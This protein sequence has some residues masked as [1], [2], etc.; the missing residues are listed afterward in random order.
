MYSMR[1]NKRVVCADGFN[2]SVQA[3]QGAYC[4]PRKDDAPCYSLVEVGFPSQED[5]YLMPYAEDPSKPTK[6][7]YA[8]VPVEVVFTVISAHGGM[9]DGEVPKGVPELRVGNGSV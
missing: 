5:R 7:V 3:H 2:M 8:W 1:R 6:T 4:E 9:I